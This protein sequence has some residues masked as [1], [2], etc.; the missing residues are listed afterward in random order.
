MD[1]LRD[2][3]PV[4]LQTLTQIKSGSKTAKSKR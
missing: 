4:Y 2:H 1:L 3:G